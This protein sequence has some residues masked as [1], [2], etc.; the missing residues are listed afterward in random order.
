MLEN[1]KLPA[2]RELANAFSELTDPVEQRARFQ[3]QI[4]NKRKSAGVKPATPA[5]QNGNPANGQEA[6]EEPFEV[7]RSDFLL[8]HRK[9][10]KFLR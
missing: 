4:D 8:F 5:A 10:T 9:T 6:D 2:G 1:V 3:A 7:S